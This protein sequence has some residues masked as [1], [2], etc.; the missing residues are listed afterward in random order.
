MFALVCV[1][2]SL[3]FYRWHVL[4]NAAHTR[5]FRRREA[6]PKDVS[7]TRHIRRAHTIRDA[8]A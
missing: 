4:P 3:R 7:H 1:P 2:G 6:G 5:S 8:R